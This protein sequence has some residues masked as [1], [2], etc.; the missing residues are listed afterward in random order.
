MGAPR[1]K[2]SRHPLTAKAVGMPPEEAA[3]VEAQ[4][5]A[6][7]AA[8]W[9]KMTCCEQAA[10]TLGIRMFQYGIKDLAQLR[11]LQELLNHLMSPAADGGLQVSQALMKLMKKRVN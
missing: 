4:M 7:L 3:K 9:E 1:I 8:S 10:M 11:E 5:N 6:D 2:K